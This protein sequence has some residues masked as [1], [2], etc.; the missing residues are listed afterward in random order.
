MKQMFSEAVFDG[1]QMAVRLS[2]VLF[3]R[4]VNVPHTVRAVLIPNETSATMKVRRFFIRAT[5]LLH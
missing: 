3:S 2:Y 5:S 1:L 4:Y